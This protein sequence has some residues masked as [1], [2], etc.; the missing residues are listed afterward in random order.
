MNST[1]FLRFVKEE[2]EKAKLSK[3]V[4]DLLRE[5]NYQP[6][7]TK[8]LNNLESIDRE[9]FYRIVLWKVDRFPS[10]SDKILTEINKLKELEPPNHRDSSARKTLECLL[11]CNGIQLPMASTLLRFRNPAVFQII[12]TRAY[13]AL[14]LGLEGKERKLYR[15]KPRGLT[16]KSLH[17]WVDESIEIYFNYLDNLWEINCQEI[18]FKDADR[19]LYQFHKKI[20]GRVKR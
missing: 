2:L 10:V 6:E 12:D 7:L 3:E 14:Y 19:I 18:P 1:G 5:Y 13:R 16:E 4:S 9:Q 11:R 15:D 17:K 8:Q 20:G